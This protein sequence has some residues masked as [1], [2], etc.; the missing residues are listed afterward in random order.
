VVQA[1]QRIGQTS[2]DMHGLARDMLKRLRPPD[3]DGL[4]LIGALQALCDQWEAQHG[5][6]CGLYA[7]LHQRLS[8][9]ACVSLYRVV[10]EA[11]NNIARHAR[12]TQVRI[13]LSAPVNAQNPQT[14]P[15]LS[16]TVQDN[17]QGM[18]G[19]HPSTDGLGLLGMRERIAALGGRISWHDA[20]PGTRVQVMLPLR[21]EITAPEVTCP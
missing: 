16:L 5:V 11:L 12:A 3:L 18:P 7:S 2:A 14:T 13:T 15:T 17:G 20:Q 8:D 6:A 21:N 1:A 10:Q 9:E 4:G 19:P